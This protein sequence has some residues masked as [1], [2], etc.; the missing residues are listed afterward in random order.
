MKHKLLFLFS[1]LVLFPALSIAQ[2]ANTHAQEFS[3]PCWADSYD[4]ENAVGA[5]GMGKSENRSLAYSLASNDAIESLARRFHVSSKAI[6]KDANTLCR[7][8]T[9]NENGE[10]VVYVSIK[11]SKSAL[12]EIIKNNN[13]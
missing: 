9:R 1:L 5:W 8:V 2:E 13:L 3:L 10:Y 11:V 4:T 7:Q 6:E 12:L